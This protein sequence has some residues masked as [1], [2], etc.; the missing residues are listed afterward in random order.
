MASSLFKLLSLPSTS[1]SSASET[2]TAQVRDGLLLF[3][4][5]DKDGLQAVKGALL[6]LRSEV[7]TNSFNVIISSLI[8]FGHDALRHQIQLLSA[9]APPV[10]QSLP[11]GEGILGMHSRD[12]RAHGLHR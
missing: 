10:Q 1:S 12:V 4:S 7:C 9:L 5:G 8:S 2:A 11:S 3:S 6:S